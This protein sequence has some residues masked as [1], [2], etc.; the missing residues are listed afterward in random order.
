MFLDG[1]RLKQVR[2]AAVGGGVISEVIGD[3]GIESAEP[4]AAFDL[5]RLER[6]VAALIEVSERLRGENRAL[7]EQVASRAQR[8]Q[9]LESELR[10]AN[11]RRQDI[12]KRVDELIA[13]ID[14]LDVQLG[15]QGGGE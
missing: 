12:A 9:T 15:S 4:D 13:Q 10:H 3:A 14:H 11:Q 6:A 1:F 8:I 2:S 5:D 7:R